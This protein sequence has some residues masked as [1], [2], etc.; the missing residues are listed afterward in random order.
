MVGG[1]IVVMVVW[2]QILN[3]QRSHSFKG[4]TSIRLTSIDDGPLELIYI[5]QYL[6]LIFNLMAQP[7]SYILTCP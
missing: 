7:E 2:P 3:V 4:T 1:A 6:K 5:Y